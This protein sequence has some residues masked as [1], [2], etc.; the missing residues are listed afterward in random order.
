VA[1]G[2]LRDHGAAALYKPNASWRDCPPTE[3]QME[4]CER[5]GLPRPRTKGEASD[6]ITLTIAERAFKKNAMVVF[7]QAVSL[8]E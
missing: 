4:L 1:N 8:H 2:V 3:K 5:W 6:L 7:P